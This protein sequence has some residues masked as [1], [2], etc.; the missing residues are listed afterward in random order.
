MK[1]K[2]K[3]AIIT[4]FVVGT[5]MFTTTVLAE[6]VS[7]TGYDQAKDSIKY[8]AECFTSKLSNYTMD[9]SMV[10]KDNGKIVNSDSTISK[11]DRI[12]SAQESTTTSTKGNKKTK[13]YYYV[14]KK[15]SINNN[16]EDNNVYYV[17]EFENGKKDSQEGFKNPFKEKN[18]GDIEKIADALVGNLKDCVVS[19]EKPDG[20]KELSGTVSEAQIPTII[21]AVS[22]YMLKSNFSMD[23]RNNP[24]GS[25][26][27]VI[28]KDAYVKEVK[29][30]M[31][32]NKNGLVENIFL[33][34]TFYGKDDKGLEHNLT[35]EA[36]YKLSNVNST[37]VNKPN[38]SGKKVE[39]FVQKDEFAN[40]EKYVGKYKNDIVLEKDGKFQKIGERTLNIT[41]CDNKTISGN[42][43]EKYM[44]GYENYAGDSSKLEFNAK[45][46]ESKYT[47][48]FN[49]EGSSEKIYM[50][51]D[52]HSSNISLHI[53]NRARSNIQDDGNFNR[54][55]E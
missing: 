27:P 18:A 8:S 49:I 21:N 28:T 36:L 41:H 2:K 23:N 3:T 12:N 6:V 50:N 7:K 14:D 44:K 38:L 35:F 46:D 9:I 40:P 10:V 48:T 1:I 33:I 26:M 53:P 13:N 5:L 37:T 30:K 25:N 52:R 45:F 29:G 24:E 54:V 20:S 15:V 42:Y 55:F 22:S 31:L 39:K 11:F 19:N 32:V 17:T 4:S 43:E 47:A 34:G 51:V 16:S